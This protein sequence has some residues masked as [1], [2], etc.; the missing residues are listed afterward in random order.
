V[1][2][3]PLAFKIDENLPD[4]VAAALRV[5]GYDATTATSQGLG[6]EEDG[7]LADVVQREARTLITLD[8][9]FADIRAYPPD[10]YAGLIVLRTA[11][12]DKRHALE[13]IN[14]LVPLLQAE[15]VHGRLWVV[16]EHAVRI[17]GED[18]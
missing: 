9:D 15:P 13:M 16:D 1:P 18:A 6:G 4:D 8:L 12:Q 17:R 14:R 3:R 11:H 10:R 7:R 5:A 2:D